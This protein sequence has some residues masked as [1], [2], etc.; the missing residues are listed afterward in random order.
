MLGEW[1]SGL[2]KKTHAEIGVRIL[3]DHLNFR[4]VV[5]LGLHLSA[6]IQ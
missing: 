5:F 2:G 6:D 3:K 1:L 4:D